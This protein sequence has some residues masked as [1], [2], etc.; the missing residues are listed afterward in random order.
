MTGDKNQNPADTFTAYTG[1]QIRMFRLQNHITL[2]TLAQWIHKSTATVSKYENGQVAPDTETLCLIADILNVSPM[3]L[4]NYNPELHVQE[5]RKTNNFFENHD[6]F[7][8]YQYFTPEQKL[9]SC[10]MEIARRTNPPDDVIFYYGVENFNNFRKCQYL[11]N[12]KIHILDTIVNI[13]LNS[14]FAFGDWFLICAKVPFSKS[15]YTYGIMNGMS[16]SMRNPCAYKVI[17]S[18]HPFPKSEQGEL[19]EMLSINNKQ[20]IADLK[21]TNTLVVF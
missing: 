2:K 14:P 9:Y 17:L 21:R 12:G 5:Q 19:I 13:I 10:V 18:D 1:R 4:I 7:Y 20:T 11:Y 15:S 3:Q 6:K 16:E 8:I